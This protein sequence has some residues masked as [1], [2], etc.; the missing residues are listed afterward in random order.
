MLRIGYTP[1]A[2][3]DVLPRLLPRF[4]AREPGVRLEL[5]EMRSALLPEALR[6]GRVEVGFACAPLRPGRGWSAEGALSSS[7]AS[8]R[9]TR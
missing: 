6:E 5:V 9:A 8:D 2:T 3:Y 7:A 1:T 4:K